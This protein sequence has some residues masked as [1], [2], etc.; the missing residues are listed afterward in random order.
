M[1]VKSC[2]NLRSVL[3]VATRLDLFCAKGRRVKVF[4]A[5]LAGA[6]VTLLNMGIRRLGWLQTLELANFDSL[7]RLQPSR[8]PDPRL[9]VVGISEAD[10]PAL[11]R[12]PMD[13]RSLKP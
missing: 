11:G 5:M 10:I 7:V 13:G 1:T 4:P 8:S 12:F 6:T 3:S 2:Q 9:L